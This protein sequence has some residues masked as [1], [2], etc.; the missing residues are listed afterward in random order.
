MMKLSE[1]TVHEYN[2][3]EES[4]VINNEIKISLGQYSSFE[5]EPDVTLRSLQVKS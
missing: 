4:S 3:R 5:N 2:K 1:M